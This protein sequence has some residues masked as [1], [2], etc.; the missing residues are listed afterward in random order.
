MGI[1]TI[2]VGMVAAFIWHWKS[3]FSY[4]LLGLFLI[5]D[6]AFFSANATKIIHGGWFPLAMGGIVFLL[7]MTWKRGRAL[8]FARREDGALPIDEFL[9][10]GGRQQEYLAAEGNGHL[11]DQ[12]H[13]RLCG[14]R[15]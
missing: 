5:V 9:R 6:I 14:R 12:Q 8:V 4:A 13:A 3:R 10:S 15:P 1:T 11:P 7:L 2:M